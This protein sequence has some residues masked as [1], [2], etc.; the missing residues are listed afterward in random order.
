MKQYLVRQ[1]C[2]QGL[3]ITLEG[4]EFHYLCHVRRCRKGQSLV[5]RDMEGKLFHALLSDVREADCTILIG[6]EGEIDGKEYSLRLLCCLPKG[7]KMDSII[8]QATEAGVQEIIP[9]YSDHSLVHIKSY[10]FEKKRVRWDKIIKEALQQSGSPVRT[11]LSNP[12]KIPDL[13]SLS[14]REMGYY[15]HQNYI[16]ENSLSPLFQNNKDSINIVIG[17]EGGLSANELN[18]LDK[19]GYTPFYLGSNVLRTETAALFAVSAVIT[20]MELI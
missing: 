2:R 20:V 11:T 14:E 8:R 1:L 3:S 9:L 4:E 16:K 17:P 15:C 12:L 18:E 7:K 5:L 6:E 10:D 13:P 19:K